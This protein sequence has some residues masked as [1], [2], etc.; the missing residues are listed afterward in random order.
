MAAIAAALREGAAPKLVTLQIY[1]NPGATEEAHQEV[2]GRRA[3]GTQG[4]WAGTGAILS[5]SVKS[6]LS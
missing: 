3:R 2:T 6:T 5:G 4:G 1:G